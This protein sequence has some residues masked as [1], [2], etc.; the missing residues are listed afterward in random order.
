MYNEYSMRKKYS[1]KYYVK[2]II[3]IFEFYYWILNFRFN[4]F[5]F[6]IVQ[7]NYLDFKVSKVFVIDD[8]QNLDILL[9]MI[10]YLRQFEIKISINLRVQLRCILKKINVF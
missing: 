8:K 1:N 5:F 4:N 9:Y 6:V 10:M 7:V 2:L 3:E